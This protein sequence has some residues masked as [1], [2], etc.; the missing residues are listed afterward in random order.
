MNGAG[1]VIR[2]MTIADVSQVYALDTLSFS[3]PWPERSYR[4]EVT[5]NEHSRPWI[6]ED[7]NQ[8]PA[9]I[10]GMIV[11]WLILDEAHVATI[12]VH[13]D[14]RRRGLG[15]KLLAHALLSAQ[16]EGAVLAYLEVRRSNAGAQELYRRFGFVVDGFRPHYYVDNGEDAILMSLRPLDPLALTALLNVGETIL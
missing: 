2:P 16:K 8:T 4:Y 15:Q 1:F 11:V 7:V 9:R 5:E 13:P 10:A 14:F 12:A 3:L 6:I